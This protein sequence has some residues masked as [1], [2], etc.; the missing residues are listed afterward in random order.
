VFR[1]PEAQSLIRLTEFHS[2]SLASRDLVLK[3]IDRSF[4]SFSDTDR[5]GCSTK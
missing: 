1:S 5:L 2:L 4:A 3:T